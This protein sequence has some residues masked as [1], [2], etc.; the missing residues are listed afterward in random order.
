MTVYAEGG[1]QPLAQ[2]ILADDGNT[3]SDQRSSGLRTV[4]VSAGGLAEGAYQVEFTASDDVFIRRLKRPDVCCRFPAVSIW[5]IPS[6]IATVR[7]RSWFG[8]AGSASRPS[9]PTMR[10]SRY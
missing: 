6:A 2:S 9:R 7:P 3:D 1:D 4:S 10:D 8:W 5:A